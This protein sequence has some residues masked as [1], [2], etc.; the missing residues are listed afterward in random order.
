[1]LPQQGFAGKTRVEKIRGDGAGRRG[2]VTENP[3]TGM[4]VVRWDDDQSEEAVLPSDCCPALS[5]PAS[6]NKG[7]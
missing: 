3:M 1:M 7:S 4:W 5:T 6:P 2:L